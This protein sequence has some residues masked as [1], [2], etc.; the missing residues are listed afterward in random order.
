MQGRS[1]LPEFVSLRVEAVHHFKNIMSK[2][3][4]NPK[5][6]SNLCV[7]GINEFKVMRL[8]DGMLKNAHPFNSKQVPPNR[9]FT[10]HLWLDRYNLIG[11][12]S[13]GEMYY[14]EGHEC[15]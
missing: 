9:T 8:T 12:T 14:I 2:I 7:S 5:E 15:M 11:C 6:N 10:E 4:F 3:S 13:D 1:N